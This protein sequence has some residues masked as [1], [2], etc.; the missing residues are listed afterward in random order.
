[1]LRHLAGREVCRLFLEAAVQ[2]LSE[3]EVNEADAADR[4]FHAANKRSGFHENRQPGPSFRVQGPLR[5]PAVV[6]LAAARRR[7][8][9]AGRRGPPAA[10]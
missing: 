8:G 3:Q 7:P 1:M 6:A 5:R 10:S 4:G 2:P 9:R